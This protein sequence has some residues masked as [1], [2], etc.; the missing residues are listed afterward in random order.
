MFPSLPVPPTPGPTPAPEPQ[1]QPDQSTVSTPLTLGM[2]LDAACQLL[3]A[4][5]INPY[6]VILLDGETE[7]P[8]LQSRLGSLHV[9]GTDYPVIRLYKPQG[10]NT[11][12]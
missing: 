3:Q 2:A 6:N 5:G 7:L 11:N 1:P 10:E 12:G 4:K 8:F 9:S